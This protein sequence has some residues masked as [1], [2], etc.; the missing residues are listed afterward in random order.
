MDLEAT[1]AG[2]N[3]KIIQVGI[4]IV[5]DGRIIQSY[6]TDVNPHERLDE[7][8]KQLTGLTDARLRKAPEFAQ[9]A[10]DIFELIEDAVFVAH[11]VKF[12]ANLLAEALFWEGFELTTPRIDTV[13][14]SQIFYPTLERYNLG[15][16]AS[17]L[18]IEL[19]HAHSALADAMATAQLL[20]KLREKIASLP[21]GLIED[22]LSMADCLIYESRLLIEDALEDS[23]LFLPSH[24]FEV[25]GLYLR[26]P[27]Q[28]LE[29][30]YLSEQFEL[31]MQLL[32]LEAYPEQS[33]FVA[34]LEESLH[35]PLPSFIEAPT[36]IGKTYA[37]LLTL[38]SKTSKRILVSVPTKI[39]QDQIM[40]KEGK[41]IQDL[42]Q[43][44]FHSLK[45]PKDYIQLDKFYETLQSDSD[46]RMIRRFKMQLLVWLTMTETG[47]LSEIGQ[48][49]RHAH[50]VSE[51]SHDGQLSKH[52]LFYQE[53][54]W[55]L[56]QEK[57]KT[58][59]VILTNHA[60]LLTRLEDDKSLLQ[61]TVLVV[62]EAQKLFFALEQFSQREE[63]LQSLLMSLQ[64]AIEEEKDLL[65]RRLLESIQ[66]ELNACSKEIQQGKT[67]VLSDQTVAKIRQDVS[68]LKNDSLEKLRE[69]FDE[70]YQT[71]WIDKEVVDSQQLLHLHAGVEDL[72]SFRDFVP[73]EVPVLFVSATIAISKKVNLPSLLGYQEQQIYQVPTQ[74]K[75]HQ[76]MLLPIDFPDVV[77]L[78]SSEYAIEISRLI[79]EL[80]PLR[81]PIFLL[82]TSKELLLETSAALKFPHLA[83]YRNGDAANIKRRFDRGESSILLGTGSFWEG[84]DFSQQREVIQ[85]I[86]RLPFDNPKNYMVQKVNSQLRQ[87]GK[88]PFYDYSLP[89]AILRLKQAI[90]RTSRF[91]EQESL[92]LLLDQ[93]VVTKRYGK[94]ILDSLQQVLP[95]HTTLRERLV[96]Q[97]ANFFKKENRE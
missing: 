40:K 89:V 75:Q 68:E 76:A 42:F 21:R 27:Q 26:K 6:E 57:V 29:S 92:V 8:I 44:P 94:Q 51:I 70:R 82:F 74:L 97:A 79:E 81:K 59:R 87:E 41:A 71:F 61:E 38:L 66:F 53:D 4:V 17:E 72:C 23:S 3:A 65:Q 48:L 35:Q 9:V 36:G 25:H 24:L 83:Q 56:G 20:L 34:Y 80:L 50:F 96:E 78:S 22:L 62:D 55:R 47:E 52:S 86:T 73:E 77:S 58:N 7:H 93:R 5:E 90:G 95:L 85:I 43:I 30:Y 60:Y 69:L 28:F 15:A 39:L 67:A 91:Q 33:Q 54:F 1:S 84:V 19:H 45:S 63:T 10:K 13:E 11:N 32:G 18:D 31:N 2:S 88:N 64:H 16:L 12:D 46:N 37:Y 49:Y 14:L